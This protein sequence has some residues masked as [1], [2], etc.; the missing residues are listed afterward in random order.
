MSKAS[1]GE[2]LHECI[3]VFI[4]LKRF[5]SKDINI[6]QAIIEEFSICGF[7]DP[8]KATDDLLNSGKLLTLLD[9]LDEV[10]GTVVNY[11]IDSIHNFCDRYDS[12]RFIISCRTAAYNYN[13]RRFSDV[14]MAE[15]SN[16]QIKQFI[17]N[18]FQSE[19]D[20]KIGTAAKCWE[21][22]QKP[23]NIGAKE[24]ANTPLLLTLLC[25]VYHRSQ[26][27]PNNRSVLYNKSLRLFLEEWAA[28]RKLCEKQFTKG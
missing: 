7:P 9:G 18:W 20:I 24:L 27:F 19:A 28:E 10:P 1:Q 14:A 6:K 3:P 26:N 13:F 8:K 4:D 5:E 2:Y 21:L 25:L 11:V 22:L 17:Y 16:N 23:E 12:N 15:F